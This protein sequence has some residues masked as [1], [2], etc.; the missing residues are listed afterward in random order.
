MNHLSINQVNKVNR[1]IH[2]PTLDRHASEDN[3]IRIEGKG[4]SLRLPFLGSLQH[5]LFQSTENTGFFTERIGTAKSKG[6]PVSDF[7]SPVGIFN[8]LLP[9]YTLKFQSANL[10]SDQLKIEDYEVTKVA[11][12]SDPIFHLSYTTNER[13][14]KLILQIFLMSDCCYIKMQSGL[15]G[16]YI[17][18]SFLQM[19]IK[20]GT[21]T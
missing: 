15:N 14:R 7:D 13:G 20:Q 10:I 21:A 19:N 12:P 6:V 8:F 1:H 16:E 11:T 5:L 17:A 9:S 18:D 3:D 4:L 2:M